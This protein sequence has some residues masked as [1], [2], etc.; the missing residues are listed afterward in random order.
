MRQT[1]LLMSLFICVFFSVNAQ[2]STDEEPVSFREG[3]I[4]SRFSVSQ[5]IRIMPALDMNRIEQE[6]AK[7]E[8]NGLPPRFGYPHE[9]SLDLENSG[10]WQELSNGDRLWQLTIRCPQALSINLLYDRFWLPEGGKF[11]IYTADQKH[12]IGAFTSINNKGGRDNVQGFA[13]GLLYGDEVTLEYYQPKQV[14]EQA[15]IS[16]SSVNSWV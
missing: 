12:S 1:I 9:V 2:I 4:P 5:D 14:T 6:D 10:H 16:V 3:N 15:I 11:F 8:A 7:D 13:T